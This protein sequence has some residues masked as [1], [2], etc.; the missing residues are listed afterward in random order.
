M[1]NDS[2]V[3]FNLSVMKITIEQITFPPAIDLDDFNLH[4]NR[5]AFDYY[6]SS[7]RPTQ[8][9]NS[10]VV[11]VKENSKK[12]RRRRNHLACCHVFLCQWGSVFFNQLRANERYN[13]NNSDQLPV[14]F[15]RFQRTTGFLVACQNKYVQ[16]TNYNNNN[17]VNKTVFGLLIHDCWWAVFH[18]YA[19][20]NRIQFKC[21]KSNA[22]FAC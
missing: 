3:Q 4:M 10:S 2:C 21:V 19:R 8:I 13:N 20:R 16:K 5:N 17:N 1:L 14:S 9:D 18:R 15:Y 22:R 11:N 6:E 12:G 7:E